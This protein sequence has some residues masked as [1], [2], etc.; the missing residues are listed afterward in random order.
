MQNN[1][2]KPGEFYRHFKNK[3]YQILHIAKYSETKEEMVVYQALYDDFGIYVRPLEMFM[4]EVDHV[5]YPLV[6]QKMRFEKVEAEE[7]QEVYHNLTTPPESI[8]T[9]VEEKQPNP[10]LMEFLDLT[11]IS[12]K[13]KFL[14]EHHQ[15]IDNDLINAMAASLDVTVDD[16]PIEQ[17]FESLQAAL[18][19]RAKYEINRFR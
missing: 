18:R 17:R 10:I 6:E 4:S 11:T 12:E 5:K 15:E 9:V 14:T 1:I 16:G 2:P 3:Y 13:S 8:F 19:T 7:V